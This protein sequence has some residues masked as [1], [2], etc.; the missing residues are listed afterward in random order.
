MKAICVDEN[1]DLQLREIEAPL[2]PPPGYVTVRIAAAAINPGDKTFLKAPGAAGGMFGNRLEDVWGASAAGTVIEA[3][4]GV[5]EHYKDRKVAIYRSLQLD[6]AVLGLWCETA[7]VPYLTCL[8][9]PESVDA[10][11]Y[12]GSLVNVATAYAFL[13][14]AAA[15]GHRGIVVTAGGSA[16]GRAVVELARRRGVP[17]VVITRDWSS[18]PDFLRELEQ[19]AAD[20]GATA[21]FDGVGGSLISRILPALPRKSSLYCYGFLDRAEPVT[22]HSSLLMMKD[23]TIRRFSN[24]ESPTV[25]DPRKLAAMLADLEGCIEDPAFRTKLGRIFDLA[26]FDAAMQYAAAH[27]AKPVFVPYS[28]MP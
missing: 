7:L 20:L 3:G 28:V 17:A 15:E 1:R 5:P 18:T 25:R 19:T 6:Q 8:P 12:S 4:E 10:R 26:D 24:F 16:T 2:A 11:D 21:V 22:F 13:E 14:Q 9:L 27:G 23:L